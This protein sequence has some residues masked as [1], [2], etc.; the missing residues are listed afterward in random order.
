MQPSMHGLLPGLILSTQK[1]REMCITRG[2]MIKKG[3]LR[4]VTFQL[5]HKKVNFV[6][7]LAEK[8]SRVR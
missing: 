6:T 7:I 3:F 5:R 1:N 8:H 4:E 2:N